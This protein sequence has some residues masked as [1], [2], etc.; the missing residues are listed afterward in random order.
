MILG[1]NPAEHCFVLSS[2]EL[3]QMSYVCVTENAHRK[4]NGNICLKARDIFFSKM[5][6]VIRGET[7][8]LKFLVGVISNRREKFK[9]SNLQE[10]PPNTFL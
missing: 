10:D 5:W 8:E 6:S 1:D 7:G 2:N 9:L 4:Q 3:F